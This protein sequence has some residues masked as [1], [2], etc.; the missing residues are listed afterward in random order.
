[1]LTLVV[2]PTANL[3]NLK[4]LVASVQSLAKTNT[5]LFALYESWMHCL[6]THRPHRRAWP[7]WCQLPVQGNRNIWLFEIFPQSCSCCSSDE[8]RS[9][10][11]CLPSHALRNREKHGNRL[12]LSSGKYFNLASTSAYY[13]V[14]F[15]LERQQPFFQTGW[16]V[17][18]VMQLKHSEVYLCN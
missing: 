4:L 5:S 7:G 13:I 14:K 15:Y 18:F 3:I 10:H 8:R 2:L 9:P 11:T 17:P 6:E 16:Q 1:M 12:Q